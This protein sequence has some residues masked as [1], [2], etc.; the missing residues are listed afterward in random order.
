MKTKFKK[1]LRPSCLCSLLFTLFCIGTVQI[2]VGDTKKTVGDACKGDPVKSC[3]EIFFTTDCTLY[4]ET[5]PKRAVPVQCKRLE[6]TDKKTHTCIP[7]AEKT[8]I[9]PKS[10]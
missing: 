6:K 10:E 9:A 3:E 1:Y 5:N 8:C 7:D 4:Y 2:A